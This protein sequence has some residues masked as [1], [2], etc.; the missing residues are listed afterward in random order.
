MRRDGSCLPDLLP[1]IRGPSL[2]TG[3]ALAHAPLAPH[4]PCGM[5]WCGLKQRPGKAR[6]SDRFPSV[7][8][9]ASSRRP[10]PWLERHR[11][12]GASKHGF[13]HLRRDLDLQHLPCP[14]R[15]AKPRDHAPGI[16]A[17]PLMAA[18]GSGPSGRRPVVA[19]A[20]VVRN[21]L[22]VPVATLPCGNRPSG[23]PI[24]PANQGHDVL[25]TPS[26]PRSRRPGELPPHHGDRFV[27]KPEAFRCQP[28]RSPGIR[29]WGK[30]SK[31][32]L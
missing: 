28:N 20:R 22:I 11:P 3:M 21:V 8:R 2:V 31:Q 27:A 14:K 1:E 6:R 9:K 16:P 7:R 23:A 19:S 5:P 24:L 17:N 30:V 12:G 15:V 32:R 4:T 18:G 26:G 29:G 25:H 13:S 10:K